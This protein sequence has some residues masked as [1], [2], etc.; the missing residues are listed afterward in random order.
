MSAQL[1]YRPKNPLE[2]YTAS[3]VLYVVIGCLAFFFMSL[4]ASARGEDLLQVAREG[5]R[6]AREAIT[7]IHL[8]IQSKT[9][10][11]EKGK[12]AAIVS[13]WG[14]WWQDGQS[15]RVRSQKRERTRPVRLKRGEKRSELADLEITKDVSSLDGLVTNLE[16]IERKDSAAPSKDIGALIGLASVR[17]KKGVL[18]FATNQDSW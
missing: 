8:T 7:S 5:H 3:L 15:Y 17:P 9:T 18:Q 2:A 1:R 10:M 11:W 12:G 16:T 13:M 14:E 4:V 6:H